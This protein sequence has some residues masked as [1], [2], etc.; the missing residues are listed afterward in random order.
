VSAFL[1][2]RLL[3]AVPLLL[4]A[5][6]LLFLLMEAIP[7]RAFTLEPGAGGGPA[8]AERLRRVYGT[9][10]PM[11]ER[12]AAWLGG[13]LAG[14]LGFSLS[15]RQPVAGAVGAAAARTALLAGLAIALQFAIGAAA[16]LLAAGGSRAVDRLVSAA[17][18]LLYAAPSFWLGLLLVDLFAVRLGWLPVS[19]MHAPGAADLAAWP[20]AADTVRH[21]VLPCL[22]LALPSAG[23]LALLVRDETRAALHGGLVRAARSRGL[24]RGRI[25][26]RHGLP[27]ALLALSTLF[28]LALPGLLGGSVV[29]ETLY[30]WPGLGRLAY[31]A[32]LARDAPLVLGCASATALVVVAGS[33]AADLLAAAIDPRVRDSLGA[34][35]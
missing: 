31:Q 26:L 19:Q 8:A 25:V 12:Y 22:A 17:A 2:R 1:L 20:W 32:T 11:T 4:G 13:L 14:D 29:I 7:G 27:R 35:A 34:G 3:A 21:L 5:V 30:A 18:A 23:G 6:T 9:D 15:E 24:T 28:G 33:V 10:R 16:G